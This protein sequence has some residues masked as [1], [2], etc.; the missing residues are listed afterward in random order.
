MVW[1]AVVDELGFE[2]A[3]TTLSEDERTVHTDFRRG[4]RPSGHET[5]D[6]ARQKLSQG[7]SLG[8]LTVTYESPEARKP[9][10]VKLELRDGISASAMSR[11]AWTYWLT[12]ADEV[13]RAGPMEVPD[14]RLAE[15]IKASVGRPG[16]RGHPA[17]FHEKVARRYRDLRLRGERAPVAAIAAEAGVSRNT[18]AGWIKQ[19]RQRGFLSQPKSS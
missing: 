1:S 5:R 18:A 11:F 16:R 2:F 12:C 17:G 13:V 10:A 15:A 3:I 14:D 7:V 8:A 4:P 19:A 9:A 6:S